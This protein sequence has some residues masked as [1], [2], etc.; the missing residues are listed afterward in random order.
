M[1]KRTADPIPICYKKEVLPPT[2]DREKRPK[3]G[4]THAHEAQ[5]HDRRIQ[6]N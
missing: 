4:A 2:L 6:K 3:Q 1:I 5:T